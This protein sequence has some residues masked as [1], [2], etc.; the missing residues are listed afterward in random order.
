M[1]QILLAGAPNL[2]MLVANLGRPTLLRVDGISAAGLQVR[3]R[4]F[5]VQNPPNW[6]TYHTLRR[7]KGKKTDTRPKGVAMCRFRVFSYLVALAAVSLAVGT[8]HADGLL[9]VQDQP[10]P[11]S[12][13]GHYPFAPLEVVYHHVSVKITDQVAVTTIDQSFRN[14][15]PRQLEGT[16]IFPIPAGAQLDKF[17]MDI[18]GK[19]VE[20]ELLDAD[21]ARKI[22]EDIVRKARDPALLE[23][24]GEGLFRA[25]V[26]PIE[27]NSEKRIQLQY[28]EL[29][30]RDSGMTEYVYPLNT[31]KFSSALIKS[32]SVTVELDCQQP[33]QALYSPSHPV[34][35]RRHGDNRAVVGFEARDVRPDTDFKLFY[36]TDTAADVGLNLLTYNDSQD[37][38]GGYFMLMASPSNRLR[39]DK[40]VA[41]DV[42]FVLDTSGSMSG[43]GKLG[44][45]KKA[46]RFCLQ[47]LNDADRFELVQF[48]TEVHA[49]FDKLAAVNKDNLERADKFIEDLK[50]IGGTAIQDALLK[51]LTYSQTPGDAD[52]PCFVV[53]LT[54]GCPTVGNTE[55]AK[56]LAAVSD[57]LGD[58]VVRMFCFGVGTDVNTHL[59][60]Q[61]AQQTKA[62]SQYVLPDEDIEV[63]VSNFYAKIST[64]VLADVK[65]SVEGDVRLEAMHPRAL[66][67]LFKGE[68]LVVFGRYT[69]SGSAT[70]TLSG[71][72]NGE[73][74]SFSQ[75][76]DFARESTERPFIPRLWAMRRVG[77]LLDQIRLHGE[78]AELREEVVVLAR[79]YG[80]VTPY[81]A[82]LIV[83]DESNR[84][85]PEARRTLQAIDKDR[86]L[87]AGGAR[88]Y[89]EN[90]TVQTGAAAVGGA[91][92]LDSLQRARSP[93]ANSQAN[94]VAQ[95]GQVGKDAAMGLRLQE[96]I[97]TQ[98]TRFVNGRMFYQNSIQ[99][100]DANV[101]QLPE[102][103][104]V[105][106]Q[107]NSDAYFELLAKHPEAAPWLA[108]GANMQLVLDDTVYEIV[109]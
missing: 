60:D 66:P 39:A 67:D 81:T 77:Y 105:Q 29:L 40:I 80:V 86:E 41:K 42:V 57:G 20:A 33:L 95:R 109:E 2:A 22:Y 50:P 4:R 94:S 12:A 3:L 89:A 30:K 58:R 103:K 46:L 62:A 13:P 14:P 93:Q 54:D 88:M 85:V 68:Q 59:L 34:D 64:P 71:V 75:E 44:Q 108:L 19:T 97:E 70:V 45:A 78:N 73:P 107:F 61:L 74:R 25:R 28:T 26:F 98:Q 92:A 21:K 15:S 8:A 76:V 43:D 100:I 84:S 72:V 91:Q 11:E 51:S 99:W 79:Q 69:N 10:T 96:A 23:Y 87:R 55:P 83:E 18:D 90:N 6:E 36:S 38:A 5:H 35:I 49:L 101:Q 82:Y 104:P 32:V 7:Q 37:T 24:I 52:R 47:N 1:P 17:S 102:A 16:Y 106:V 63:K 65:L 27:P 56:I 31:E 48:S 9:V 53:F